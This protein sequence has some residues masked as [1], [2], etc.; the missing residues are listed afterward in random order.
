MLMQGRLKRPVKD[1]RCD[2]MSELPSRGRVCM[3]IPTKL[4]VC[5]NNNRTLFRGM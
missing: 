5:C 2:L 3:S 4:L 1:E